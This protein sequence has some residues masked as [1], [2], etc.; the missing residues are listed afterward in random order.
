MNE[1]EEM[2]NSEIIKY[3][4]KLMTAITIITTIIITII[5]VINNN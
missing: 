4:N 5:A 2:I 3:K 1:I